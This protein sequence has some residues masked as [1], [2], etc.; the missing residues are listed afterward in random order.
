VTFGCL[1]ASSLLYLRRQGWQEAG[2]SGYSHRFMKIAAIQKLSLIDYPDKIAA[3]IFTSGCNFRCPY[4]HNPEL[5]NPLPESFSTVSEAELFQFLEKRQGKIEAVTITGGEPTLY[6]DLPE[7]IKKIKDLGFLVKLDTNGTNPTMLKKLLTEKL[8]DYVAMD[9]KAPFSRYEE[10]VGRKVDVAAINKSIGLIKSSGID[11][12]FRSTIL[13]RLFD[14]K[15]IKKMAGLIRGAK[16]YF[17]QNFTNQGKVL[18]EDFRTEKGFKSEELKRLAA[19]GREFVK[20]CR[21]R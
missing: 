12:E 5:V 18:A 20:E 1:L 6:S 16:R 7:L 3:I 13:P 11:Y 2:N 17:L 8:V 19:A 21:T 14:E 4:C 10:V 15:D 9:I